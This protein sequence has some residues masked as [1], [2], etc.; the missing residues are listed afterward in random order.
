MSFLKSLVRRVKRTVRSVATAAIGGALSNAAG[1]LIRPLGSRISR[2]LGNL[3][4]RA[5]S[6]LRSIFTRRANTLVTKNIPPP[7]SPFGS[8]GGGGFA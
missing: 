2:N 6:G 3:A 4:R 5:V 8:G 1:A 7:S